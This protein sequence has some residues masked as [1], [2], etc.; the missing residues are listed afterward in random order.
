[1][2]LLVFGL[3]LIRSVFERE[4]LLNFLPDAPT[5]P[6]VFRNLLSLVQEQ[7]QEQ[8]QALVVLKD[9]R[10][11]R[12]DFRLLRKISLMLGSFR[13]HLAFLPEESLT[14]M[15]DLPS[16]REV[17]PEVFRKNVRMLRNDSGFLWK[18]S[19]YGF[20]LDGKGQAVEFL[21][22]CR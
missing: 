12:K 9:S 1:M 3:E 6:E 15:E 19:S 4:G 21:P 14:L 20:P 13:Y 18:D 5:I 10:L 11:L 16:R 17:F 7:V 2:R 22:E 8:V